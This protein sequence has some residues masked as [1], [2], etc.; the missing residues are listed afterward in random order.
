MHIRNEWKERKR[1]NSSE[2]DEALYDMYEIELKGF[3]GEK[4]CNHF[5]EQRKVFNILGDLY[6]T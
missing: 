4:N 1:K 6:S 3:S 2:C 5:R